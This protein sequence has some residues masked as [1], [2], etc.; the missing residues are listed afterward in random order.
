MIYNITSIPDHI[1]SSSILN[2]KNI[3]IKSLPWN[4]NKSAD[5]SAVI[6]KMIKTC[7]EDDGIGLAAPQ[8]GIFKQL[9]I[10]RQLDSLNKPLDGFISY[11]NPQWKAIPQD[12]KEIDT[13]ACLSVP[14][15][16]YEVSRWKTIVAQYYQLTNDETFIKIEETM[17]GYPARVYQHEWNHLQARSIV[18]EGKKK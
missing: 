18:D 14:G 3:K 8:I 4:V 11:F 9:F 1:K 16:A 12:G 6:W 2:Y 10:I 13:E 5:P 15:A 17:T 7:L